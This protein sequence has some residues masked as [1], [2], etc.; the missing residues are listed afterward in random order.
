[1]IVIVWKKVRNHIADKIKPKRE[2]REIFTHSKEIFP[3]SHSYPSRRSDFVSPKAEDRLI[4]SFV[5]RHKKINKVMF[6]N[7]LQFQE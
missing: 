5:N 6:F 4:A 3:W 1:M 7:L 2:T